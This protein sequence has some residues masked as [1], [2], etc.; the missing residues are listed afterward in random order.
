MSRQIQNLHF[1]ISV[2]RQPRSQ[3]LS[4]PPLRP[5]ER[6]WWKEKSEIT[7]FSVRKYCECKLYGKN[8]Y[9]TIRRLKVTIRSSKHLATLLVNWAGK[10]GV[11][12]LHYNSKLRGNLL[13]RLFVRIPRIMYQSNR[14][15]NIPPPLAT[16][17]AFE[18]LENFCSNSPLTGRKAVQMFFFASEAV[19]VNMVY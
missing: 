5:W 8:V 17:R 12:A 9:H 19:H 18:F 13:T 2:E 16:P 14:S 3:G 1:D 15:F 11:M 10:C 4:S 6:G 7:S